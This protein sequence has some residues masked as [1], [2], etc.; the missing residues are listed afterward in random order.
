MLSFEAMH[1]D[2]VTAEL[3]SW[4]AQRDGICSF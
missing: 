2:V 3:E 4:V 1:V